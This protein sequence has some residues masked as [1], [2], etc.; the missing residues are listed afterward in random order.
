MLLLLLLLL[1]FLRP[2]L[3]LLLLHL[4]L[5]LRV[6]ASLAVPLL[7]L[8]KSG[9]LHAAVSLLSALVEGG[10]P[11]GGPLGLGAPPA[12]QHAVSLLL[13]HCA[14]EAPKMNSILFLQLAV[15]QHIRIHQQGAPMRGSIENLLIYLGAPMGPLSS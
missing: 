2:L 15:S 12:C 3:L 13:K 7:P 9:G 14:A 10:G 11:L 8:E 5:L 1:L 4:L 6:H